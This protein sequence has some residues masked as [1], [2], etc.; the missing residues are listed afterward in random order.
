MEY[1]LIISKQPNCKTCG[2]PMFEW[3]PFAGE[4]EHW[5]CAAGRISTILVNNLIK[6]LKSW[7][8]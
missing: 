7:K 8:N 3:D 6:Q 5:G 4:H 1:K 2:R